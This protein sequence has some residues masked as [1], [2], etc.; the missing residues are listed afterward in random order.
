MNSSRAAVLNGTHIETLVLGHPS[1]PGNLIDD[2]VHK[3]EIKSCC[4]YHP[5]TGCRYSKRR[6][7]QFK[8]KFEQHQYLCHIDGYYLFC[9]QDE[10]LGTIIHKKKVRALEIEEKYKFL[11]RC[12]TKHHYFSLNWKK[13]LK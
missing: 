5:V 7:G 4:E 9:V 13:A 8:I 1:H 10:D 6:A 2:P 12:I 11:K 3:T